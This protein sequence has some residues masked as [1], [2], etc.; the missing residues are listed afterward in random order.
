M[1]STSIFKT[2]SLVFFT[3]LIILTVIGTLWLL[4]ELLNGKIYYILLIIPIIALWFIGIALMKVHDNK[5]VFMIYKFF[6]SL[7]EEYLKIAS[8]EATCPICDGKIDLTSSRLKELGKRSYIGKC[9][10]NPNDH[11]FSFDHIT[12]NGK[13]L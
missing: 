8:Y 1:G 12:L 10:N 9:K 3:L 6:L 4:K 7:K 13:R 11:L 2:F 5:F